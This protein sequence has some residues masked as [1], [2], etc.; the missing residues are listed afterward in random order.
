MDHCVAIREKM[1]LDVRDATENEQYLKQLNDLNTFCT[2]WWRTQYMKEVCD[3][4]VMM[5]V[6]N[7]PV[8]LALKRAWGEAN[9][10]NPGE[11]S[12]IRDAVVRGLSKG[13]E[14]LEEKEN[15]LLSILN[16]KYGNKPT[17][18]HLVS[19]YL[20]LKQPLDPTKR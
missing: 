18:T 17:D 14:W 9:A 12:R 7:I 3:H 13:R 2:G 11:I 19:T 10:E 1:G 4:C 6:I 5:N 8:W 15:E 20:Q 16:W